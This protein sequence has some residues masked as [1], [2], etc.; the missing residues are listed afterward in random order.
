MGLK[1]A[2]KDVVKDDL[3]FN[4]AVNQIEE[5]NYRNIDNDSPVVSEDGF[6]H[7]SN[8]NFFFLFVKIS[9]LFFNKQSGYTLS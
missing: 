6:K 2:N 8:S 9:I 4:E 7:S 3:G 5:E 1:K